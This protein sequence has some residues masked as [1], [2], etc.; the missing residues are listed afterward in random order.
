MKIEKLAYNDCYDNYIDD[1]K[2]Y[3]VFYG[4]A[5]SGKSYFV[6]QRSIL[7]LATEKNRNFLIIRKVDRTNRD[8]TFALA[9]QILSC[10]NM[11]DYF[12]I[13]QSEMVIT[14]LSNS[15]QMIFRGLDNPEKI[16]SITFQNGILTDIWIEE[17]TE[18][19]PQDFKTLRLRLR[20]A[21][22]VGKQITMSFNPISSLHWI[23][24]A[25][26]DQN[27]FGEDISI[28]KT[29]YKD[30]MFLE[31][32]DKAEIERL[33]SEDYQY[34]RVYAL[35]EWGIIG[36][37]IFDN[38]VI[39]DFNYK[40]IDFDSTCIGMDFGTNHPFAIEKIGFKDGELYIYDEVYV[41]SLTNSEVIAK[42]ESENFLQRHDYIIADSAEPDRIKEWQQSGYRVIPAKKGKGSV[43]FGID[44]L[45]RKRIHIHSKKCP[46]I[47][48]EFTTYKWKEDKDGNVLDEP[49]GFKD[50][51]IAALRYATESIWSKPEIRPSVVTAADLGL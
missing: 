9:K 33:K 10:L 17:A 35:G 25:I 37:I 43:R 20:G 8:S 36:N 1:R 41:K 39:E 46:G 19:T 6:M 3:N 47:A 38:F 26:F 5:G 51:G 28:C 23:K 15:N 22:D 49:I 2:R 50:D 14:C 48:S 30:N 18:L 7:R 40:P 24:Q 32:A 44:Y 34:Y 45:R 21:S 42:C 31:E 13:N 16:K 12:K 27:L 11:A 29:T 4:G